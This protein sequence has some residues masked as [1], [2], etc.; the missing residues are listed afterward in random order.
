M[1]PILCLN[2]FLL[3]FTS[4][5]VLA[6]KTIFS[7]HFEKDAAKDISLQ[8][9]TDPIAFIERTK[10]FKETTIDKN[11]SFKI[12][13]EL[14]HP[15]MINVMNGKDWLVYNIIINPGDS[16]YMV[17]TDSSTSI[18]GKGS[19]EMDFMFEHAR[20]YLSDPVVIKEYNSSYVRLS[21]LEYGKYWQQR[22]ED[23][24]R[25]LKKQFKDTPANESFARAFEYEVQYKSGVQLSQY[26]WRRR[27]DHRYL[28]SIPGYM[29]YFS[30]IRLNN[31][32]ALISGE[33]INFLRELPYGMWTS[34][35]GDWDN[36]DEESKYYINNSLKI[37]DSIAGVY[38]KGPVYDV[39]LYQ[40]LYE[41]IQA[42]GSSRGTPLFDSMY[43]V[44]VLTLSQY[45]A[46]FKND[47][48]G[49]RLETKLADMKRANSPAPDFT[50]YDEQGKIVKLSDLK[51]K[52]V[53][54]DFWS[55]SC[56]PCVEELP[57]TKKLQEQ[58]KDNKDIV[59]LYVSLDNSEQRAKNFIALKDFKGTHWFS[60]EGFSSDAAKKYNIR[61]IPR[62][63]LIDKNGLLVNDN[64]PRPS[65]HP[66]L[67]LSEALR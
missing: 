58:F 51:G 46:K 24:V 53:Y 50:A 61:A 31:P 22:H 3:F 8:Y 44:A 62:Y 49:K 18:D 33:Y 38:F 64:A 12:E 28:F 13:F 16:I 20:K 41:H 17:F 45:I 30:N 26:A 15:V 21:A 43:T 25:F 47:T 37:R 66:E 39:A 36:P 2:L 23:Q 9:T 4:H 48:L 14:D 42:L 60:P 59:F 6:K 63:L 5:G 56:V 10:V 1:K 7:G 52:M 19:N 67:L 54:V 35:I 34:N 65:A 57:A 40:L 55:T 32:D 29:E 11:K 27:K